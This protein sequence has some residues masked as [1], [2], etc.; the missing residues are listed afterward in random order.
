[1]NLFEKIR[2]FLFG[3]KSKNLKLV[4]EILKA[5]N[6]LLEAQEIKLEY[7]KSKTKYFRTTREIKKEELELL[8]K[9]VGKSKSTS[10]MK[11]IEEKIESIKTNSEKNDLEIKKSK[12]EIKE[13]KDIKRFIER[14]IKRFKD[15][16]TRDIDLTNMKKQ[17][18][19][20]K[21]NYKLKK[22]LDRLTQLNTNVPE[23]RQRRAN[24]G[25]EA[26]VKLGRVKKD[27][28]YQKSLRNSTRS[29]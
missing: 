17:I 14:K 28:K 6:N 20:I 25:Q 9:R 10:K 5:N 16:K 8:R 24:N 2:D 12:I 26:K 19:E 27:E 1:M 21:Q 15:G 13:Y 22:D 29:Y 3:R 7:L 4:K 11:E 18:E 23:K